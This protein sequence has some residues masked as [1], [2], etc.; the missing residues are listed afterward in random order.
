MNP[1]NCDQLQENCTELL[2]FS[3]LSCRSTFQ[4]F[5][6][7][8]GRARI[9]NAQRRVGGVLLFDGF[10]FCQLLVGESVTVLALAQHISTD[11][12]H[13]R[14]RILAQENRK[15]DYK[16]AHWLAGFCEPDDLSAVAQRQGRA[17]LEQFRAILPRAD[18]FH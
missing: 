12:R 4:V 7:I 9:A 18:L 17:A 10:R 1:K 13:E 8:C 15:P 16:P 14:W 5:G 6:D 11:H 3:Y 2:T